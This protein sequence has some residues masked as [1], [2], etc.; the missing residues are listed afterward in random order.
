MIPINKGMSDKF[1]VTYAQD[2]IIFLEY[3]PGNNF[4]LV[5]SGK[6]KISKISK[7]AEKILDILGPGDIFGEMA[8]LE[9]APRSASAIA[10]EETRLL[11]FRKENF[12]VILQSSPDMALKLLSILAK[13]IYVQK[14]RLTGIALET[15]DA[16]VL[17]AL[18]ML[19]EQEG[20]S[21]T[22][23]SAI[24]IKT[25]A[26][27]VASWAAVKPESCRKIL[28]HY[29]KLRRIKVSKD[30]IILQNV[31]EIQRLTSAKRR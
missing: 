19:A 26:E 30:T 18:L 25:N 2:E 27:T 29:D 16:K 10:A 4:F 21:L 7:D 1:G 31:S 13:R 9:S 15:D 28:S 6:V 5:Q 14:R 20:H 12:D 17:H 3:E 22:S 8:I 11:E 24:E 23:S